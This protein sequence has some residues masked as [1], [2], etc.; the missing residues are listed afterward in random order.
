M[1]ERFNRL[2]HRAPPRAVLLRAV[3][4][5]RAH[6]LVERRRVP[7]VGA[8]GRHEGRVLAEH[9]ELRRERDDLRHELLQA[10]I[11]RR[12]LRRRAAGRARRAGLAGLVDERADATVGPQPRDAAL[13]RIGLVRIELGLDRGRAGGRGAADDEPQ[14]RV[15]EVAR[16]DE[17]LVAHEQVGQ[18]RGKHLLEAL[19]RDGAVASED[20]E[21]RLGQHRPEEPAVDLAHLDLHV[22]AGQDVAA[23]RAALAGERVEQRRVDVG[24]D[25]EGEQAAVVTVAR[26]DAVADAGLV[27]EPDRGHAVGQE[28]HDGQEALGRGLPDRELQRAVD[29]GPARG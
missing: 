13:P 2:A 3:G 25:A 5:H 18:A 10:R 15:A 14:R 16:A 24:A 28:Q 23:R 19:A 26:G 27:A 22:L 20:G 11:V 8:L 17:E 7:Q 12:G 29:V 21:H 6:A 1:R 9:T 4:H